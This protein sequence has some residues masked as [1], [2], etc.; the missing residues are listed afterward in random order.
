MELKINIETILIVGTKSCDH[1]SLC[2]KDLPY[3]YIKAFPSDFCVLELKC[4]TGTG[5]EYVEKHFP[6]M[7]Y[8]YI[9]D[10]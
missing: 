10:S 9:S 6:G 1:I 3:P 2:T 5:K 7:P 4:P 8:K